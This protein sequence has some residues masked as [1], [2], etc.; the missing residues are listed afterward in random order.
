MPLS[1]ATEP[2]MAGVGEAG[3]ESQLG[4]LETQLWLS[5][6]TSAVSQLMPSSQSSQ[7]L[8]RSQLL[9]SSSS[10]DVVTCSIS[11]LSS[12]ILN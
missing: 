6:H 9:P 7:A 1:S 4:D 2:Y 5:S 12:Q 3:L 11:L 10:R 8:A